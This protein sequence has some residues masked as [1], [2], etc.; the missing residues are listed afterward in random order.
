MINL[1]MDIIDI[2][3]K[4]SIF[5]S[6]TSNDERIC[7]L[8]YSHEEFFRNAKIYTININ[9]FYIEICIA[10]L[11]NR[12]YESI[13]VN[14]GV[15]VSDVDINISDKFRIMTQTKEQLLKQKNI[16]LPDYS[17]FIDSK[18]EQVELHFHN[19]CKLIYENKHSFPSVLINP[20]FIMSN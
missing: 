3:N 12:S 4:G 13:C 17:I 7:L 18:I 11:S 1:S 5:N 10:K 2:I 15:N 9:G 6:I 19:G 8:S 16:P 20:L 14:Q